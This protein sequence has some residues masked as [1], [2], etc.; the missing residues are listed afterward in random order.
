M[1][2]RL[3]AI[4]A[5]P[6]ASVRPVRWVEKKEHRVLQRIRIPVQSSQREKIETLHRAKTSLTRSKACLLA[7]NKVLLK[8]LKQVKD[9][10]KSLQNEYL[11]Q[12]TYFSMQCLSAAK[13]T[14]KRNRRYT[15]DWLLRCLLAHIRSSSTYSLLRNN[16]ILSLPCIHQ[17]DGP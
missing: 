5:T 10:M 17:H 1:A 14:T 8:E 4:F 13:R 9:K 3:A 11:H 16:D 7:R 2:A 12:H 15:D 6:C